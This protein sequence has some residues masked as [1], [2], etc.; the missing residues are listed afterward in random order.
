MREESTREQ[1]LLVGLSVVGHVVLLALLAVNLELMPRPPPQPVRLAIQATVV[2]SKALQ[3]QA[4]ARQRQQEQAV[5]RQRQ[6]VERERQ[7]EQRERQAERQRQEELRLAKQQ[8]REQA[9]LTRKQEQQRKQEV[10]KLRLAKIEE[11]RKQT[12][13][14]K[15]EA[16][17][18]KRRADD[19]RRQAQAR[20]ELARQM[21]EEEELQSAAAA[22]LLDQYAEI[23][24][25]KVERN[26]IR[27]ASAR[28]GLQCVVLVKQ[29]PGGEVIEVRVA[30]CNGDAAVVRS[31]E[32]AVF[33]SSPLP[34]P[35]NPSLFDRSLRFEF[36]PEE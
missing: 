11:Q 26:W 4:A 30:E 32:A 19:E 1:A 5:E 25:Q 33:R 9:E 29:I 20:T 16:A 22:G 17:E 12:E 2:D 18:A 35:P 13:R 6:A 28:P 7:A 14:Q 15:K 3:R 24:R 31:I 27:P 21:A 10:E 34:P 23:I 8:R 36:K